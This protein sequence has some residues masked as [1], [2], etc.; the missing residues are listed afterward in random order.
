VEKVLLRNGPDSLHTLTLGSPT[1][2]C[3]KKMCHLAD[4][5]ARAAYYGVVMRTQLFW[6]AP[7]FMCGD[8]GSSPA[9]RSNL[10]PGSSLGNVEGL[11]GLLVGWTQ[12]DVEEKSNAFSSSL[13]AQ[14]E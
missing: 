4:V 14:K 11:V 13:G 7:C 6:R 12:R 2:S 9:V 8:V 1:H 5:L 3:A 10:R